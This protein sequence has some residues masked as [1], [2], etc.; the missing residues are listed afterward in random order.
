MR[1]GTSAEVY[2]TKDLPDVEWEV[3]LSG[4]KVNGSV[5]RASEDTSQAFKDTG[6]NSDEAVLGACQP[7]E[8][9]Y[10]PCAIS[11][12]QAEASL[13]KTCEA[14]GITSPLVKA[15]LLLQLKRK[16]SLP[17]DLPAGCRL[18]CRSQRQQG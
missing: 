18:G 8:P 6:K 11:L 13:L 16:A 9:W 5:R 4:R 10:P 7:K 1:S 12:K 14:T 15:E 2:P 17:H 3:D